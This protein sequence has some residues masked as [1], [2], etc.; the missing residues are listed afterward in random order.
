[1]EKTNH[2]FIIQTALLTGKLLL[3]SGAEISRVEDTM[4]RIIRKSL[5]NEC[6]KSYYTYV[7]LSGVFV[8]TNLEES[9]FLRIDERGY[10][11]ETIVFVNQVSRDYHD[12]KITFSEL[13]RLLG[14]LD[15]NKKQDQ[16]SKRLLFTALLS[17]SV[18]LIFGGKF[19]DL[20]SSIIAGVVAYWL[21]Q[22]LTEKA[23]YPFIF[24]FI[25]TFLSG[26]VGFL[27]FHF[28]G[29]NINMTMIGTVVPLVPGIGITNS[30]R[31]LMS[32]QYIS[33]II[34]LVE[35]LFIAAALGLGVALVF[36]IFN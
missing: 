25:S 3:E 11:L 36:I 30:I 28:V 13:A 10:N 24:E 20:P 17:G 32:R 14:E 16:L 21:F 33:G 29:A 23:D 19:V 31:D 5:G 8:K 27:V 18:V 12:D 2:A 22:K 6:T 4:E 1:M 7:T 34:R 9:S 35:S 15:S 26:L